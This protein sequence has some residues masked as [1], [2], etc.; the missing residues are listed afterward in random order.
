MVMTTYIYNPK[1]SPDHSKY[2]KFIK[3]GNTYMFGFGN[4]LYK[5]VNT[6][7]LANKNRTAISAWC[8]GEMLIDDLLRHPELITFTEDSHPEYFI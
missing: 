8:L 6:T 3:T 5:L 7:C 2:G 4:D 1:A